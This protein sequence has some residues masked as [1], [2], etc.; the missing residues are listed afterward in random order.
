MNEDDPDPILDAR[1]MRRSS[2]PALAEAVPESGQEAGPGL[3]RLLRRRPSGEVPLGY[4]Q[5][6]KADMKKL[7][8]RIEQTKKKNGI[9]QSSS[10]KMVKA[11]GASAPKVNT[12]SHSKIDL[13]DESL[14]RLH[15]KLAGIEEEDE[16]DEEDQVRT[17][18]IEEPPSSSDSSDDS[19]IENT[20]PDLRS[21]I[22]EECFINRRLKI[23]SVTNAYEGLIM[24]EENE[25][26]TYL[27]SERYRQ[28][29]EDDFPEFLKVIKKTRLEGHTSVE[30]ASILTEDNFKDS[31]RRSF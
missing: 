21:T 24:A 7:G 17:N 29:F 9:N 25:K 26:K 22:K 31:V 3:S 13:N 27:S 6:L 2:K 28:V 16:E 12:S 1:P 5:D 18:T 14:S 4:L 19:N 10:E 15:K 30:G 8:E 20:K 11:L 23:K